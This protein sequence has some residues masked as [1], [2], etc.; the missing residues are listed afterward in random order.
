MRIPDPDAHRLSGG[1]HGKQGHQAL[2]VKKLRHGIAE[3][4][5]ACDPCRYAAGENLDN[6]TEYLRII[7]DGCN[8][9]EDRFA[10][11]DSRLVAEKLRD[12]KRS[13]HRISPGMKRV[14]LG[15]DLPDRLVA[16]LAA[17]QYESQP[18]LADRAF[19]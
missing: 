2:Q 1:G 12:E 17:Q 15:S 3:S 5:A 18:S 16:L 7:R 10:T 4:N 6:P 14:T 8:T 13:P 19:Y 9:L 11:T